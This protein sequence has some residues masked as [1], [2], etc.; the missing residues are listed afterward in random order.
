MTH[1]PGAPQLTAFS[2]LGLNGVTAEPCLLDADMRCWHVLFAR[3][4]RYATKNPELHGHKKKPANLG[5]MRAESSLARLNK[6]T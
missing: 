3:T 2:S 1:Y 4:D 5:G 6:T